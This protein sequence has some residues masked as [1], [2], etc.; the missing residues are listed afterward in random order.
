MP[1]LGIYF[2]ANNQ[3]LVQ[4]VLSSKSVDEGRKGVLFTGFLTMLTLFYHCHTGCDCPPFVSGL[5]KPDMV[6]PN[7]VLQLIP[8]GLLGIMLA[9]L[10]VCFDFYF[11]R[12]S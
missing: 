1:V 10:F 7:M 3:T 8:V 5:E 11:E 2:W 6:Y 4:R 12:Y 9:A